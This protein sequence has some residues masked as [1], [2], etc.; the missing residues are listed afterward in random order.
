MGIGTTFHI[1]LPIEGEKKS[2]AIPIQE[3][4]SQTLDPIQATILLIEDEETVR[5][6]IEHTLSSMGYQILVAK[7]GFEALEIVMKNSAID[8][9]LTDV[10]LP[11]MNGGKTAEKIKEIIPEI[12][13]LFMSGYAAN[14]F[15]AKGIMKN[16]TWFL[17]K[18]FTQEQLATMIKDILS[19]SNFQVT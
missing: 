18:P 1:F 9:L 10:V 19:V 17:Q 5:K 12:R 6:F 15:L 3:F 4:N 7:D 13:I 2:E 16:D 8:I 11:K 14:V